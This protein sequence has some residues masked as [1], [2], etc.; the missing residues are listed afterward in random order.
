MREFRLESDSL[1]FP[2]PC[3]VNLYFYRGIVDILISSQL[4]S[5][6]P[7]I[8]LHLISEDNNDLIFK[9]TENVGDLDLTLRVC[10]IFWRK[11]TR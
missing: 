10:I 8:S 7:H 5:F 1:F 6:F 11:L 4:L 3:T 9:D 2:S